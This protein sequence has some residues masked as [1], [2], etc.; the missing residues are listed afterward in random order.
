MKRKH[1]IGQLWP[2]LRFYPW[3]IPAI[4]GIG[5]LG[6]LSEGIG[7]S[8]FIP[9]LQSVD[10]QAFQPNSGIWIVDKLAAIFSTVPTDQRL[11]IIA[12]CILG[13]IVLK[14]SLSFA[15][16]VLFGWLDA[17]I[18]HRLRS[19]VFRQMLDVS[20]R[21]LARSNSGRLLN[22]LTT[23]TWQTSRALSLLVGLIITTINLIVYVLLLLLL[24]WQLTVLVLLVM[25]F[26]A[27]CVRL[28]TRR[29]K[30]L[31]QKATQANAAL[32]TRM[33]EGFW[34]M[35]LIRTFGR[36]A[37][38]QERFDLASRRVSRIF[39][40]LNIVSG[41]VNPVYE[42]LAAMLLVVILVGTLHTAQNLPVFLVFLFV[43]YRLQPQVKSLDGIRVG[44]T[45]VQASVDEVLSFLQRDDKEYVMS[46]RVPYQALAEAIRFE[47]VTFRYESSESLALQDVTFRIPAGR[48]TAI[49]GP[50]GAG[51]TTIINLILRLF[52][53]S[54][55]T[56]FIDDHPLD[57]LDLGNWRDQIALVS[58][59]VT[60]FNASVR[61]N[62]AY[63]R[64]D[65]SD[66]EI[67]TAAK[68]AD[69][70]D[71]IC[72]LPQGYQ[73]DLGDQ[74]ARLSG[75]QQQ[76]LS[77]AR[78]IVRDPKILIL[79]EATNAL[80]SISED[81]IQQALGALQRDRTIIVIAH[82]LSTV[83]HADQIIVLD[84]GRVQE[85]G[86][87]SQLLDQDNLFARL[88]HF[89]YRSMLTNVS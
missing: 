1:I 84:K 74:G 62:I 82:R 33:L 47:H 54:S 61:D 25:S 32:A 40:K 67:I 24:S 8:L 17:R 50:S 64:L 14:A 3:G 83:E 28:L 44:L 19:G 60:L 56:V 63:G 16:G 73:T 15:N 34:S 41:T 46:G 77:L 7:I 29:V 6:S 71:F 23:E 43:L 21:Y 35:K 81:V 70:H 27:G 78:A 4:V 85:Q 57:T 22:V 87:F 48:T 76:R 86:T 49:V 45:G 89:Q 5:V 10:A 13:S 39:L 79:D 59:D 72:C 88:Y 51:K 52:E 30:A 55:G 20:Y 26:I 68:L 53:P 31:G 36:E 66:E 58:Q 65:A 37:Y 38:E 42:V 69:A 75:G 11:Y 9:F 18:S 2:L 12:A 80:D